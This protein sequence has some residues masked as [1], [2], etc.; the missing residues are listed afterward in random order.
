MAPKRGALREFTVCIETRPMLALDA[1]A[2]HLFQDAIDN[3][4]GIYDPVCCYDEGNGSLSVIAQVDATATH[5]AAH[6]ASLSVVQALVDAGL[7]IN[8]D[9][10]EKLTAEEYRDDPTALYYPAEVRT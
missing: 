6:R 3:Q 10:I 8:L 4:F 9:I 7:T 1:Y 2:L 5:L